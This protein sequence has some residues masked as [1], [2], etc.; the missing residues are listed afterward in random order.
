VASG[1]NPPPDLVDAIF[2]SH[3]IS[4]PWASLRATGIANR[5]YATRDVV[6][7]LATDHLEAIEDA[8]TES[9]AA[10]AAYDAG[11]LTPR[12]IAFD[13][14][15]SLIDRPFSLWERVRGET[16]GL[17][18]LG[19]T[20]S[21]SAWRAVGR[22]LSKL[23]HQV[24]ACPDPH[25]YLDH[26]GRELGLD[27]MLEVAAASGC[28]RSAD[29]EEA[30]AMISELRPQVAVDVDARFIH[31]DIHDMNIMCSPTGALRA[32]IDW[33]DAGW[34]DPTLEFIAIP[35]QA[36]TYALDGYESETPGA[37]GDFAHA[38]IIW[39]K[40]HLMLEEAWRTP[41]DSLRVDA[42]RDLLRSR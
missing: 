20:D 21:A 26:P 36:T 12:L 4:G 3:G 24:T 19:E 29:A 27:A 17:V 10:P 13:D 7:R 31:N 42:L 35:L 39:D 14:S 32:L 30:A 40:L 2:A 6:L 8:R 15:R 33:G 28:V 1:I 25:G 5:I 16:L 37:L 9:V 18:A 38:R 22:E 11:I 41:G 34:G 23:H